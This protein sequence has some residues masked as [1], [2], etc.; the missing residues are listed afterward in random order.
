MTF[1]I[2]WGKYMFSLLQGALRRLDTRR[3]VK[4]D[5]S[6]HDALDDFRWMVADLKNRPTHLHEWFPHRDFH[7][8]ACD[9]SKSGM[10]GMCFPLDKQLAPI[11]WHCPFPSSVQDEVVSE[12]NPKGK[13]TNSDIELAATLA[14]LDVATTHVAAPRH[15]LSVLSDNSAAGNKRKLLIHSGPGIHP[16]TTGNAPEAPSLSRAI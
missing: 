14:H 3:R 15:T 16:P 1:A 11:V 7:L 12:D 6:L 2:L 4:L 9:A 10:G 13:L 5:L 8:G